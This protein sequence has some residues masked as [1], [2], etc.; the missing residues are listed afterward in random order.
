MWVVNSNPSAPPNTSPH[1][2][3]ISS[4]QEAEKRG[5]TAYRS[6]PRPCQREISSPLAEAASDGETCN[7]GRSPR[8]DTTRPLATRRPEAKAAEN[9]ASCAPGK[10]DPNTSAVVVPAAAKP[11]TNSAATPA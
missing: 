8:S 4:E 5:V 10:C 6:R 9:S 2:A 11:R 3:S 7:E 1:T